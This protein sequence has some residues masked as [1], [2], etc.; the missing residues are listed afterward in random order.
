VQ[1]AGGQVHLARG[2]K[3]LLPESKVSQVH[4]WGWLND[5][6]ME[7]PPSNVVLAIA[8]SLGWRVTPHE[9]RADLYPNPTDALPANIALLVA[10]GRWPE[11]ATNVATVE[12]KAA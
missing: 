7:V 9:L 11:R 3:A 2:I 1:L 4:V 6:K 5:V 10:T 8:E 12:Q